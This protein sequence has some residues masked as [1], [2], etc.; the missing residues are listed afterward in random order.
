MNHIYLMGIIINRGMREKFLQFFK[1]YHIEVTF[2]SLGRGT[3]SSS[4]LDY[5][6]MEAAEKAVYVAVVTRKT[7]IQLKKGLYT[8]LRI[9]VPGRGIAFLIPLSSVGGKKVLQYLTAG[10]KLE[11][12]E[13]SVL[14]NTEYELLVT[15]ANSGY[16]ETI[17][18]AARSAHAPGGTV[19]HAKGTGAEHAKTFLGISL[20]EE[21]EMVFI[22]VKTSQKNEIM[23]AIMEKAG[24]GTKAGGVIGYRRDPTDRGRT[25]RGVTDSEN[26]SAAGYLSCS[27]LYDRQ[28]ILMLFLIES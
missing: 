10:Q 4:L 14:K 15:I 24:T 11:I 9:D 12:E 21:K 17:M 16:T 22:V 5:L 23:R 7:W 19:I 28:G 27:F 25:G 2:A 3:A 13:E 8:R 26:K 20:A 18:D 6:G 1:E